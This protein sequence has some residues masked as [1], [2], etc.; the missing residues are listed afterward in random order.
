MPGALLGA[1][2]QL[3]PRL[4]GLHH[5]VGQWHEVVRREGP[6]QLHRQTELTVARRELLGQGGKLGGARPLDQIGAVE[7]HLASAP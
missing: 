1:A 7:N 5:G 6:A 3:D 2:H 4:R